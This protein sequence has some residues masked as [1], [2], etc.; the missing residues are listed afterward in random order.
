MASLLSWEEMRGVMKL[1]SAAEFNRRR[2]DSNMAKKPG[3]GIRTLAGFVLRPEHGEDLEFVYDLY[4]SNRADEMEMVN[5][6]EQETQD[7]LRMQFAAQ[8]KYYHEHYAKARFDIIEQAGKAIGHLYV[9]RWP[10]EINILDI[11]SR[12]NTGRAPMAAA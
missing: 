6:T 10:D 9:A 1:D 5:W 12:R 8:R 4:S 3:E 2:R 7:F 11:H